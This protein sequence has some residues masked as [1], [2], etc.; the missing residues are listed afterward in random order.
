MAAYGAGALDKPLKGIMSDTGVAS[1]FN[2]AEER[3]QGVRKR[4]WEEMEKMLEVLDFV[5]GARV[6]SSPGDSS[7]FT[8]ETSPTTASVTLRLPADTRLTENQTRTVANLVSRGLGIDKEDLIISDQF[9]NGLYDGEEGVDEDKAVKELLDHQAE[10]DRRAT[11]RANELLTDILGPNK[12]RVTVSSE[13]DYDQSTT[14]TE[15]A[16]AK[17]ALV[18]ETKTSSEKPLSENAPPPPAAGVTS[19]VA[20]GGAPG[21][22]ELAPAPEVEPL[23]EKTSDERKEYRPTITTEEK[24]R[25]VPTLERMSIALFLDQSLDAA[26]IP[27]LEEAVKAA[28]GFDSAR[29]G[30]EG[31]R[32]VVL[33][34][35]ADLTEI[36]EDPATT[37]A[38]TAPVEEK[39]RLVE[40]LLRRGVEIVTAVVFIFLLLRSLKSSKRSTLQ[41]A[42]PE[43][44][45]TEEIDPELLARAQ[46]EELLQSDP[47]RVGEI[48][49]SWAR[50]DR[51]TTGART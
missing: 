5:L 9:G 32:S 36:G 10:Y 1:V 12:A 40:T 38:S 15:S 39:S 7:P 19:N 27:G 26:R 13:W 31:F 37:T 22:D 16:A 29:D 28:L 41:P 11:R 44:A 35:A 50:G 48:L 43:P 49:S 21:D 33:P 24:T 42:S 23:V 47:E 45:S 18:S 2:S 17:G 25:F 51:Q 14:R 4:E 34:F 6:R 46:V 20:L 3:Q 30:E 8:G